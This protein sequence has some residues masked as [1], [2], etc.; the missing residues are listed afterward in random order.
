MA[1]AVS[2]FEA[3]ELSAQSKDDPRSND[4][5]LVIEEGASVRDSHADG[6]ESEAQPKTITAANVGE[7]ETD[8]KRGSSIRG[9]S[10]RRGDEGPAVADLR[11]ALVSLKLLPAQLETDRV[12]AKF[13]SIVEGIIRKFQEGRGLP[14]DGIVGPL[15]QSDGH[16]AV[17]GA[18]PACRII[19]LEQ[20]AGLVVASQ[21]REGIPRPRSS[22]DPARTS[23]P[24]C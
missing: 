6:S 21:T 5:Q 17:H 2:R 23:S 19:L 1:R 15:R 10:L 22:T 3:R 7:L 24:P 8:S 11:G 20:S 16:W 14:V 18:A 13:D 4:G 9:F 12:N